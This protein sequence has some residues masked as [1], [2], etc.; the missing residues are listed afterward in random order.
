VLVNVVN[1]FASTA[2]APAP[3]SFNSHTLND[4]VNNVDGAAPDDEAVIPIL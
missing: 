1:P 3:G 4:P 2:F